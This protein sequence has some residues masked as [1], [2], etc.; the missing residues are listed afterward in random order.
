MRFDLVEVVN[1]L[2][3]VQII[4]TSKF[5]LETVKKN[6]TSTLSSTAGIERFCV[7]AAMLIMCTSSML[8]IIRIEV[9]TTL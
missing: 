3:Q 7:A 6:L 5:K 8:E 2:I 9:A 4:H 1:V